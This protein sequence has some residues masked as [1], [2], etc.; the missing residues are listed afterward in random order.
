MTRSGFS[1]IES[2]IYVA[3]LAVVAGLFFGILLTTT[4]FQASGTANVEVGNQLNF[5][6]E[7][8]QRLIRESSNIEFIG[9]DIVDVNNPNFNEGDNSVTTTIEHAYL[10]LRMKDEAKDPTCISLLHDGSISVTQGHNDSSLMEKSACKKPV[11]ADRLTSPSVTVAT[12][13][14]APGLAFTKIS[15]PS[16][17]DTIQIDLT[18]TYANSAPE[19]Q[20]AKTIKTA[21]GRASAATFDGGLFPAQANTLNIGDAA[22]QW[23]DGFFSGNLTAE[24]DA[25]FGKSN[26]GYLQF[27]RSGAGSPPSQDCGDASKL[28]RFYLDT[29][30]SGG[31]RLYVCTGTSGWK[32]TRLN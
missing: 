16:A 31:P 24:G 21:V 30:T 10:T 5:V 18:L 14:N 27:K 20:I 26:A 8:I 17:R 12:A 29:S 4:R 6:L 19:N 25:T 1:L 2:L 22:N 9:N 32:W 23:K 28:G 11:D 13:L 3:I 7:T 15:A